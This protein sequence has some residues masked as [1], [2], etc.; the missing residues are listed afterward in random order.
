MDPRSAKKLTNYFQ[1]IWHLALPQ[2]HEMGITIAIKDKNIC[3]DISKITWVLWCGIWKYIKWDTA[4][5][6]NGI[7]IKDKNIGYDISEIKL[8]LWCG[9]MN[10]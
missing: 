7:T 9:N 3:Y 5:L 10:K 1:L 2:C 4:L 8:V 6:W